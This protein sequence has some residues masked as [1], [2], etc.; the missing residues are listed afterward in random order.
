MPTEILE[1][2][3]SFRPEIDN[4]LLT[5]DR[6]FRGISGRYLQAV[7]K[8]PPNPPHRHNLRRKDKPGCGPPICTII[9]MR[10][11]TF[12]S[13]CHM[14]EYLI[15]N[16]RYRTIFDVQKGSCEESSKYNFHRFFPSFS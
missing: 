10:V 6:K 4:P 11:K 1:G 9:D 5:R 7:K 16:G 2:A 8:Q 3:K 12:K 14:V 13:M 15:D